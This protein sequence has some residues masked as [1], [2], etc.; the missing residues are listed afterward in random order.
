VKPASPA[1]D[2]KP[3]EQSDDEIPEEPTSEKKKKGKNS[4]VGMKRTRKSRDQICKLQQLYEDTKGKPTKMQLKQLS[5]D[6]G[7]KL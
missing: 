2:E 7:L 5:K 6:T 1:E 3:E 4:L